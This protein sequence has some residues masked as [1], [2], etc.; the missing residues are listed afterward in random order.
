LSETHYNDYQ[1]YRASVQNTIDNSAGYLVVDTWI[2]L[3]LDKTR[4][5]EYLES[6]GH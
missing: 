4:Y 2:A 1:R 6:F 3:E 5:L